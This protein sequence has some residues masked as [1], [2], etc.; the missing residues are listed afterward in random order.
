[1][2]CTMWAV[3]LRLEAFYDVDGLHWL[4]LYLLLLIYYN[5]R[6]FKL[7]Y[8]SSFG[9]VL[10]NLFHQFTLVKVK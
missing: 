2:P 3:A 1:M 9:K 6:A 7:E 10:D 5:C 8:A 4:L